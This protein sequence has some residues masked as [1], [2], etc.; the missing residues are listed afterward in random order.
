VA[1]STFLGLELAAVF[2][3]RLPAVFSQ[4]VEGSDLVANQFIAGALL[5]RGLLCKDNA[6][7][8]KQAHNTTYYKD[9]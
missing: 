9:A 4:G 6:E 5:G 7:S 1:A 2:R 8:G 3:F